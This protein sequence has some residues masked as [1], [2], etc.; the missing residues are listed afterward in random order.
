V[1]YGEVEEIAGSFEEFQVLMNDPSWQ[2]A[3]L[4]SEYV[5]RLHGVGKV[6]RGTQ[7]YALAPPAIFGGPDPWDQ[8]SLDPAAA[9]LM[10]TETL[11]SVYAHVVRASLQ[12]GA[13]T[14][15]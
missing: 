1:F 4:L 14:G 7:S 15:R 11:Q 13:D 5:F 3:Y 8:I 6:A 9:S 10:E 12:S 2:E